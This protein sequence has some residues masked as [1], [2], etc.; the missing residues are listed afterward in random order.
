M[1]K[2]LFPSLALQNIRKNSKF[3]LPYILTI[4][5]TVAGFY[6]ICAIASDEGVSK[7]RGAQYVSLMMFLGINIIGI[8]AVIFLLYTNS[9]LMKRRHKE[10]ALYNILGMEK[11]HIAAILCYESLYVALIGIIGG[12]L[13][14]ILL[15]KLAT[16]T[17]FKLL[18]FEVPFGF[19][20]STVAI[21][22]SIVL[23]TSIIGI[24]LLLNLRR[25]RTANPIELLNSSGSGEKEPKSNW[26]LAIIGI[27]TLGG[28][29]YIALTTKSAVKALTVYF[30]A[31]F[32]VI[33]GTYCLFTSISIVVLKQL[34]RNKKLYYKT[35]H[36]IGISGMLYRMKQNAVGL[37]NICVLSTMVLVMVSGTLSLYLGTEDMLD[38]HYPG[39]IV[40]QV[41][42]NSETENVFQK[43][44]MVEKIKDIVNKNNG[45]ITRFD[46]YT[47]LAFTVGKGEGYYHT[48][49][50]QSYN[51]EYLQLCFITEKDYAK[52][53][54]K[55]A[56][57]KENEILFF[58]DTL[59]NTENIR[60]EVGDYSL[61]FTIVEHLDSFP[62]IGNL[63]TYI[64]DVYYG[65]VK[66][67]EVL[68][69][70]YQGQKSAYNEYASN[71]V[72]A[73]I[74]DIDQEEDI[75]IKCAEDIRNLSLEDDIGE[76]KHFNVETR[77]RITTE[78]YALNGGFLFLG[79]FLGFLFIMAT[80]LII[81]YK[82]IS[83]GYEDKGRFEIM[84]KV[85]L[86]KNEIKRSISTQ[87]LIVFFAPLVVAAIHVAFDFRL[88]LQLLSLFALT[89]VKLT[90][91]CT[92][93]TLLGFTVIY[94]IVYGLTARTYYKIVSTK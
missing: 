51:V 71:L 15:H 33:I 40:P 24:T 58:G 90:M 64:A 6:I 83:E 19:R 63:S 61:D 42:I 78:F 11:R 4:I 67:E 54:G 49:I 73:A 50:E 46:D 89:N 31:V 14:G 9:F 93:G 69:T 72:W 38:K 62:T 52:L 79:L 55:E 3:Y 1:R 26:L 35:K 8:F 53:T 65:V 34:R 56:E 17:L 41:T 10:L 39:Q 88:M 23:F 81:Y 25:I 12:L 85:G 16:L 82:Q 66:D 2:G 91:L 5:G 29:Y 86:P 22:I 75:Q 18:H 30:I 36:F 87:I 68:K 77:A 59:N 47:Y 28:G 27:L 43:D 7:L 76:Y 74:I 60:V 94:G 80:V 37:S 84:Q 92:L 57:L 13:C 70:L 45:N 21:T 44:L 20:I 32:L 48:N